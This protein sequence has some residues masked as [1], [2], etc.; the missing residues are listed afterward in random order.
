MTLGIEAV[1]PPQEAAPEGPLARLRQQRRALVAQGTE[2][3]EHPGYS[4][5]F[6]T[7]KRLAAEDTSR[8]LFGDGDDG[9]LERNAQL[10]IE[11]CDGL[12]FRDP[13]GDLE[14]TGY[15]QELADALEIETDPHADMGQVRQIVLGTFGGHEQP[16]L[17]HAVAV[18]TW[19]LTLRKTDEETLLGGST[20]NRASR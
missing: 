14:F 11:A 6:V 4:G 13:A 16:M 12:A 8:I 9:P 10:L 18:Y 2:E 7:Y 17:Q 1:T 3:F 15:D 19:M 20:G 5:L